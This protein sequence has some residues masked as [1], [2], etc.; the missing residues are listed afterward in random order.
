[1]SCYLS[2]VNTFGVL[3]VFDVCTAEGRELTVDWTDKPVEDG[4]DLTAHGVVKPEKLTVEGFQ[5]AWPLTPVPGNDPQRVIDAD[6]L[7]RKLAKACAS[8]TL[9]TNWWSTEVVITKVGGK[10]ATSDGDGL[11]LSL[12]VKTISRP[13]TEAT[14]IPPSRLAPKVRKRATKKP[15]PKAGTG[16]PVSGKTEDEIKS[17]AKK[18]KLSV[19]G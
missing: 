14:Q 16:K 9:T 2:D 18:I 7:L 4:A 12:E 11:G 19:R 3:F 15:D 6:A 10:Q 17:W 8:V 13:K 5:T 1:M